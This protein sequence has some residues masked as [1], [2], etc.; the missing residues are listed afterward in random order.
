M[1]QEQNKNI[2]EGHRKRLRDEFF[3]HPQP[4]KLPEHKILEQLL[5]YA[6]VRKDNK[7]ASISNLKNNDISL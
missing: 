4:Y 7:V 1:K 6:I 2:H 5:S 3:S